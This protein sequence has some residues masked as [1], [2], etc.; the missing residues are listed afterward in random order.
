[1]FRFQ[2]ILI[3]AGI[4]ALGFIGGW[5]IGVNS[6][7]FNKKE[8]E[9]SSVVVENVEKVL[10]LVALEANLSELYKYQDYYS[11]DISFLRKKAILRVNAKVSVG[12]D[13]NKIDI[14]VD[15]LKRK[16]IM[17][18]LP[19]AEILAIDHNLDY[20][21]IEQGIFNRF[22]TADYNHINSKAKEYILNVALS[23]NILKEANDQKAEVITLIKN[24]VRGMGYELE[25]RSDNEQLPQPAKN[26]KG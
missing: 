25:I 14:R 4:I 1:M 13:L 2:K 5:F 6:N 15:S 20:Y 10:K 11:Y 16:V 18:S 26:Y 24:M 17:N 8:I 21:D 3:T 9:K 23:K 7:L 12:Y 19:I 22:E